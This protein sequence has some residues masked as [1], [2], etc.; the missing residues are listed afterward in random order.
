MT[1]PANTTDTG[2][3]QLRAFIERI[4][5]MREEAKAINDD[6]REIYAE[7]KANGFDKTVLGKV[8]LYV[9]KRSKDA[10]AVQESDAL[11]ELYL[12]AFDNGTRNATRAHAH[13]ADV[14]QGI[15]QRP[16]T[17][18]DTGSNPVV[19]T[20]SADPTH[21]AADQSTGNV[22]GSAGRSH[23]GCH[24]STE[25]PASVPVD[26]NFHLQHD[27]GDRADPD[28]HSLVGSSNSNLQD[29]LGDQAGAAAAG[30]S[31][32]CDMRRDSLK[33]VGLSIG[34]ADIPHEGQIH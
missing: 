20:N 33:P 30:M 9:E 24:L 10:S 8:V 11:F 13:D 29:D 32:T 15:D 6:I 17:P 16:P 19:S 5:R 12:E 3:T 2:G 18:Q 1:K 25:S 34:A 4:M 26:T 23:S 7:A 28:P 14:D 31:N 27:A 22:D 21:V